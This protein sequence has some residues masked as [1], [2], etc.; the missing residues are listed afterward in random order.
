[1]K[2]P[3]TGDM[4]I[5]D[6]EKYAGFISHATAVYNSLAPAAPLAAPPRHRKRPRAGAE[7][8]EE[9]R[10]R[11]KYLTKKLNETSHLQS[12]VDAG[13]DPCAQQVEKLA[14]RGELEEELAAVTEALAVLP[15]LARATTRRRCLIARPCPGG[16]C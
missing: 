6:I 16:F 4:Q 13:L 2:H 11:A 5:E 12:R 10:R 7:T 1:M 15:P 3:F 14:R 9:L 8:A